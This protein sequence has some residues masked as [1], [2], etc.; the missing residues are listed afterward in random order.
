MA[1]QCNRRGETRGFLDICPS[2]PVILVG[3][4][5]ADNYSNHHEAK[6]LEFAPTSAYPPSPR[7]A[8]RTDA[9]RRARVPVIRRGPAKDRGWR[10]Q[11]NSKCDKAPTAIDRLICL[12]PSLA[13]LEMPRSAQP[14]RTIWTGL[15]VPLTATR[16][17]PTSAF[18][19]TG[20][21]WRA[22]RR[23]SR[24]QTPHPRAPGMRARLRA[25]RASTST[26][27]RCCGTSSR[28]R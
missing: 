4:L 24:N 18:G 27:W 16:E 5:G 8:Y 19:T 17:P 28:A 14:F 10:G 12:E 20:A 25:C 11:P 1:H 3:Q 26:G 23:R 13:A 22:R 2:P 21:R 15:R 6:N 9:G 7:L